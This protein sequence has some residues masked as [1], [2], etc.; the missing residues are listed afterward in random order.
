MNERAKGESQGE[1]GGRREESAR[2]ESEYVGLT[3]RREEK[4]RE[5]EVVLEERIQPR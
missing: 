5:E 4:R 2:L 3:D 1:E